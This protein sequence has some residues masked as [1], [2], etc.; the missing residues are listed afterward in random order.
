MGEIS[1]A[2]KR[3]RL[4][5]ENRAD[6]TRAAVLTQVP[7]LERLDPPEAPK[8][9]PLAEVAERPEPAAAPRG[10][11]EISRAASGDWTARAVLVEPHGAATERFRQFALRVR[12]RLEQRHQSTVLVTSA[13]HG[14]GKTTVACNLALALASMTSG[15]RVAL[16][17]LDLRRPSVA[18]RLGI[19][20]RAKLPHVLA[21]EVPLDAARIDTEFGNFDVYAN[22]ASI[23]DS[24]VL[25]AG[26]P[27]RELVGSLVDR[28]ETVV[29]DGPPVL[30]LSDA[31]LILEC[32][33]SCVAV[34][35]RGVTRLAALRE[36]LEHLPPDKML[37]EFLN[38]AVHAR[39]TYGYYQYP[40][41]RSDGEAS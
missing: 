25:L 9:E 36:A 31:A 27:L 10:R 33:E 24:H 13:L 40:P 16:V 23:H 35:R 39:H 37:G 19:A 12:R 2:L 30:L 8:F 7:D 17:D 18:R 5:R 28:Y 21:G 29:F 11:C 34:A 3:A 38:E 41:K 15:G 32:V 6:A 26:G 1:E 14:E 4:E 22:D 20:P